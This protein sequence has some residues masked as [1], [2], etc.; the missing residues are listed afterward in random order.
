MSM[1]SPLDSMAML[2]H[3]VQKTF[4]MG[5]SLRTLRWEITLG[6][7]GGPKGIKWIRKSRE[8]QSCP[9]RRIWPIVSGCEGE[10]KGSWV[11]ECG[12]PQEGGNGPQL[13]ASRK[14]GTASCNQEEL[15]SANSASEQGRASPEPSGGNTDCKGINVCCFS[16]LSG[17][18]NL[19]WHQ[20]KPNKALF[21]PQKIKAKIIS[22]KATLLHCW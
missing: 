3:A 21:F 2:P 14:T 4:L 17:G 15:N 13:T 20:Q 18:A 5:P 6:Y 7:P 19:L 11:K 8:G 16:P 22:Q 10:R 9:T 1:S 12:Q